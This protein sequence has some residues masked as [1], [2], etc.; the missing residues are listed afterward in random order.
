MPEDS[1]RRI[2]LSRDHYSHAFAPP[3]CLQLKHIHS[4][5]ISRQIEFEAMCAGAQ[6]P[7]GDDRHLLT[8][9]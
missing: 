4:G 7:F 3:D 8:D 9:G 1:E 6:F 2:T 5:D